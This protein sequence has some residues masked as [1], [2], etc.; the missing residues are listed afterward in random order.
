MIHSHRTHI[1]EVVGIVKEEMTLLNEVDKPGSDV[2]V[3]AKGL[4]KI[5]LKKIQIISEIR[6]RL[7]NFY[8][9]LKT[10]EHMSKLYE[11]NQ[12][13]ANEG[14]GGMDQDVDTQITYD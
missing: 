5:L 8:S 11:R 4:D 10:E 14:T 9:H 2:E 12:E 6:E 7:L 1:D 3:Y 13:M